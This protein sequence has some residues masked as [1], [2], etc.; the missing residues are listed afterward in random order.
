MT[1]NIDQAAF[2]GRLWAL[3]ANLM[4]AIKMLNQ[5]ACYKPEYSFCAAISMHRDLQ[6]SA[7]APLE[8]RD[9]EEDMGEP[10][11]LA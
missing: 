2:V 8:Y 10:V 9:F 5:Q 6:K 7:F 1:L 4:E 3:E 11:K